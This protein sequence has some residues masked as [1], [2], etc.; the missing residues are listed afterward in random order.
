MG[1]LEPLIPEPLPNVRPVLLLD[2]GI[3]VLVV[4]AGTSE[5]D[6]PPP[7]LEVPDEVPVQELR[8]VVT[9]KA[10]QREWQGGLD[11]LNLGQD[12]GLPF[13]PD[14]PLF[15]PACGEIGGIEGVDERPGQGHAAVGYSVGFEE[16]GAGFVPL[17]GPDRQL[18][19]Q[20]PARLGGGQG[21]A[22][23]LHP[24]GTQEPIDRGRRDGQE[25][26]TDRHWEVAEGVLVWPQP[27]RQD[28]LEAL[29]ARVVGGLP[30]TLEGGV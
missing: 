5:L 8:T 17:V 24:D 9:I 13:A 19:A 3:V 26:L 10:S 28:G 22:R 27:Q 16:P 14:G 20:E 23:R 11:G 18:V 15:G 2:M 29:G 6:G 21:M 25:R 30:D 7:I 12:I 1:L 4:G